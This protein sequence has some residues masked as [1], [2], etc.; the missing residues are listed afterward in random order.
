MN[1][2]GLTVQDIQVERVSYR[3]RCLAVEYYVMKTGDAAVE[4]PSAFRPHPDFMDAFNKLSEIFTRHMEFRS[5]MKT[6]ITP[7]ELLRHSTDDGV[8]YTINAELSCKKAKG[9]AKIRTPRLEP[10]TELHWTVKDKKG[11]PL[12]NPDEEL[13][14]LTAEETA[15]VNNILNEAALFIIEGKQAENPQKDL[16]DAAD[17]IVDKFN[18]EHE[19]PEEDRDNEEDDEG[20]DSFNRYF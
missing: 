16:F 3:N 18:E 20:L 10:T 1:K 6:R 5:D 7:L 13:N 4:T 9:R 17:S 19:V 11:K 15:A 14:C 8:R 2:E 12:H